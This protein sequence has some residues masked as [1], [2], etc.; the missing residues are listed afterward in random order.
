MTQKVGHLARGILVVPLS[1]QVKQKLLPSV[2]PIQ[3]NCLRMIDRIDM[4]RVR[5]VFFD[6]GSTLVDERIAYDRRV[7]EMISGTNVT[8]EAFDSARITFAHQGL[9]GNAAAI[10]YFGLRKTPWHSED[11]KPFEDAEE[12]LA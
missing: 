12:T 9:D 11:E 4:E 2:M 1:I 8:F 3:Y 5:W 10:R 6:I 7:R